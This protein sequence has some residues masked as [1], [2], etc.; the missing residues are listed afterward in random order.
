VVQNDINGS[1]PL[2]WSVHYW[3]FGVIMIIIII[4]SSSSSLSD[5]WWVCFVGMTGPMCLGRIFV[6][7]IGFAVFSDIWLCLVCFNARTYVGS[8]LAP[9]LVVGTHTQKLIIPFIQRSIPGSRNNMPGPA[10][11]TPAE[12]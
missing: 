5:F 12:T 7:T 8:A 1:K 3:V 4:S 9:Q 10:K 6:I 11:P 2:R